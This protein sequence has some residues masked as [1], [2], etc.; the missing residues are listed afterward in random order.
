M[1][2]FMSLACCC[3]VHI[4]ELFQRSRRLI[5]THHYWCA[6]HLLKLVWLHLGLS[7]NY[8]RA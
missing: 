5:G 6:A 7:D 4:P 1:K 2:V 8:R 3:N